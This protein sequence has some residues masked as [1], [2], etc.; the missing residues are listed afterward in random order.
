MNMWP[1][2]IYQTT[3]VPHY[4]F[5]W[6]EVVLHPDSAD[7]KNVDSIGRRSLAKSA[8]IHFL[9]FESI[10]S[11]EV[12]IA[13]NDH[14]FVVFVGGVFGDVEWSCPDNLT[15]KDEEFIPEDWYAGYNSNPL[16]L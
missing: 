2:H 14:V 13:D 8:G 1:G 9:K 10:V 16:D 7:T 12:R 3:N 11:G 6:G 15:V 4:L 5:L